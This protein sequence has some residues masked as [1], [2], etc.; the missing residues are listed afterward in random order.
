M[1]HNDNDLLRRQG[2]ALYRLHRRN[3][4]I[5]SLLSISA[6]NHGNILYH[7]CYPSKFT[8]QIDSVHWH[9][10]NDFLGFQYMFDSRD[11]R[12]NSKR[13]WRKG[14]FSLILSQDRF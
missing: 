9:L 4:F 7:V 13:L 10:Q 3:E 8:W 14:W 11:S 1:I 12:L 6:D 5:P 2:L